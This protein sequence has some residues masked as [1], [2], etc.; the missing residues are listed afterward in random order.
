MKLQDIM[1]GF[2]GLYQGQNLPECCL[3]YHKRKQ[4]Q[5]HRT[6]KSKNKMV[7]NEQA[8]LVYPI[9]AL[10]EIF[11]HCLRVKWS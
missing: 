5:A 10:L 4:T 2:R 8:F 7:V 9:V 3:Y 11:K 1:M 6:C